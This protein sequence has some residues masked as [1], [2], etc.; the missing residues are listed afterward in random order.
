MATTL[1][2]VGVQWGDEGKGKIVHLLGKR[3]D[4]VVRYQGGNNAGHTVIFDGKHFVLHLI[5]SGILEPGKKC[6]IGNGV[7][8]DP[9]ALKEEIEF[10]EKRRIRVRGRLFVSDAAHVILP[11]HRHLDCLHEDRAGVG[12]IGTT[13]RGI[14]P[15]YSDK[16]GRVGIRIVDYLNQDV[17]LPLLESNLKEKAPLLQTFGSLDQIRDD[18]LKNYD[19]LRAYLEPYVVDGPIFLEKAGAARQKI[20]FE[21]AQGTMLDVDFGTYPFVTSSNPVAGGVSIGSGLAPTRIDEVL[22]VLKAY[23]TRVGEGPFPT[24]LKDDLGEKLRQRGMEFGAT[25]GRPRRCGWFDAVAVRHAVRVNGSRWLALTK[26][27]VLEGIH[28]LKIAVAYRAKGQLFKEFPNDRQLQAE[29]EPAYEEMPGFE[30]SI[31]GLRRY[32]QLPV[33][34]RNYIQRLEKLVGAKVAMVS[35]GRSREETIVLD[36]KFPWKP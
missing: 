32:K 19:A 1:V 35:L 31:R 18:V 28:P 12:K 15:A 30:G 20:L 22:G 29:A 9:E 34:A 16:V 8:V 23:T 6:L 11:Y 14:G 27:D 2:V 10:L 4:V 33:N 24:E 3:A 13:R 7:V 26:L 25:T 17:F 5:P 21:S 36:G